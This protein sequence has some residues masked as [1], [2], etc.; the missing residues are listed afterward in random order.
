MLIMNIFLLQVNDELTEL[1]CQQLMDISVTAAAPNGFQ[2][3][4]DVNAFF[5]DIY[6]DLSIKSLSLTPHPPAHE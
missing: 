5:Y 1:Q 3:L 4:P 2:S 6:F